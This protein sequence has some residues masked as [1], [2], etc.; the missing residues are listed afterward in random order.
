MIPST[1]DRFLFKKFFLSR[2]GNRY[3]SLIAC[4]A[5]AGFVLGICALIVVMSIMKGFEHQITSKLHNISPNYLLT[6]THRP[7]VQALN[8]I[9][10]H[11]NPDQQMTLTVPLKG[12]LQHGALGENLIDIKLMDHASFNRLRPFIIDGHPDYAPLIGSEAAKRLFLPTGARVH[13]SIPSLSEDPLGLVPKSIQVTIDGRVQT[14]A[15]HIDEY[16]IFLPEEILSISDIPEGGYHELHLFGVFSP[17]LIQEIV[18]LSGARSAKSWEEQNQLL[19]LALWLEQ[20][21][22]NV[23]LW[24]IV[25]VAISS[26]I[27]LLTIFFTDRK[28]TLGVLLCLGFSEKKLRRMMT[29]FGLIIGLVGSIFGVCL[30]AAVLTYI[31]FSNTFKLPQIYYQRDFPIQVNFGFV[32]IVVG[33]SLLACYVISRWISY[34]LL[35]EPVLKHLGEDPVV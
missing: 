22:M 16:S 9:R 32:G 11:L 17:Q 20:I 2:R 31:H 6:Y 10:S 14:G 26:I 13:I 35:R 1:L 24:L 15:Y 23:F 12:F 33:V 3:V 29:S 4:F 28:R 5:I 18:S 19:L 8:Q 27:S 21:S 25:G 30:A 34:R 7:S